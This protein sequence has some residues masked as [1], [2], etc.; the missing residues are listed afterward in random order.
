MQVG[1][2]VRTSGEAYKGGAHG[3]RTKKTVGNAVLFCG[4]GNFSRMDRNRVRQHFDSVPHSG[5]RLRRLH[6]F[7]HDYRH[8]ARRRCAWRKQDCTSVRQ[9]M[10]GSRCCHLPHRVN[11]L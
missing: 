7:Q 4:N 1:I 10:A 8:H 3:G 6:R 11:M 9:V 2:I 5:K